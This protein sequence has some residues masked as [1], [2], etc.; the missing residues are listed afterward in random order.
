[1]ALD[2][3]AAASDQFSVSFLCEILCLSVVKISEALTTEVTEFH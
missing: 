2:E 1:M 3:T